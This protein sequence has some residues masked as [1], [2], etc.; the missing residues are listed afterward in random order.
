MSSLIQRSPALGIVNFQ[1][2]LIMYVSCSGQSRAMMA[3]KSDVLVNETRK[4]VRL[5]YVMYYVSEN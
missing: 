1:K 2:L 4:A 3:G 5:V